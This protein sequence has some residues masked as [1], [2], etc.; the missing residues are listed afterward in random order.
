MATKELRTGTKLFIEEFLALGETD[1]KMEL[2]YGKLYIMGT[3]NK[4]HQFLKR[5]I[6]QPIEA[7]LDGFD[8]PPA[9]LHDEITTILSRELHLALEPDIVIILAGR[10]DIGGIVYVEGV[11]D[12]AAEI[13]SSDRSRDLVRK[14]QIYAENGV[15][16]YWIIDPVADTVTPLELHGNR[17][18][19]RAD[20]GIGDTLTTPLLPGLEIPLGAIFQHRRRPPRE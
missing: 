13:L 7:Y 18:I 9:E 1:E 15:R 17:Y 16:E 2:E 10:S 4:D 20:L 8:E 3:A 6:C 5:H 19:E 12:I 11:S 14:R